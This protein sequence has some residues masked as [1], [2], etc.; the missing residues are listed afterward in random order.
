MESESVLKRTSMGIKKLLV[1]NVGSYQYEMMLATRNDGWLRIEVS[2][3]MDNLEDQRKFFEPSNHRK[4]IKYAEQ[5]IGVIR[6]FL[7]QMDCIYKVSHKDMINHF[8]GKRHGFQNT[9]FAHNTDLICVIYA[10]SQTR[11]KFV[12]LVQPAPV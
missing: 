4:N 10:K 11:G 3:Y 1:E 9:V 6:C 7:N 12:G 5:L 2:F 8:F